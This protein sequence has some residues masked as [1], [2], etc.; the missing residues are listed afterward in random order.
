MP[1]FTE[2]WLDDPTVLQLNFDEQASGSAPATNDYLKD[3]RGYGLDGTGSNGPTFVEGDPRYNNGAALRFTG[4]TDEVRIDDVGV[5]MTDFEAEDSF[6]LEAVFRTT[7][8]SGTSAN[9]TGPLISKDVGASR[10]SYWLRIQDS[11]VRFLVSDGN[12]EPNLSSDVIVNDGEWHHVAAVRDAAEGTLS[13]Y[14]DYQFAGSIPDTSTG[15]FGN[16]NDMLIGAF[17]DSSGTTNKQFIG[18]IDFVRVSQAAL[19]ILDFVQPFILAG[20]LDGDGFVG[21]SDLDLILGSW[22]LSVPVDDVAD[23]SGDG[24]VG[25]GD[26]DIVLGNWN[27]GTAPGNTAAPEPSSLSMLL[28]GGWFMIPRICHR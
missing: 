13:L 20:D 27:A 17:N 6:T 4:G 10:A 9:T 19:S 21:L 11:R 2:D 16:A 26:L 12:H 23:P 5:S 7:E 18:D 15:D 3:S 14:V 25:L 8:H 24:Y 1:L 22:N 28:L